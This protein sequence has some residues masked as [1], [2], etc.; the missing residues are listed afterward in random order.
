MAKPAYIF[1]L[2]QLLSVGEFVLSMFV[3]LLLRLR[4]AVSQ[5]VAMQTSNVLKIPK[6]WRETNL[7]EDLRSFYFNLFVFF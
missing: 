1:V 4:C 3:F 7:D 5:R 2:A 6:R